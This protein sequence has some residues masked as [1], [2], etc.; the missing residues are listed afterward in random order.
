MINH[1]YTFYSFSNN[2]LNYVLHLNEKA[3]RILL[4]ILQ[5][6]GL[7]ELVTLLLPDEDFNWDELG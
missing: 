6:S 2:I 5:T 1:T 4:L 3:L 7:D